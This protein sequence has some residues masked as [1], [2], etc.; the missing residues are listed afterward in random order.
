MHS[1]QYVLKRCQ[2]ELR[3]LLLSSLMG[4]QGRG[5][6]IRFVEEHVWCISAM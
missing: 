2:Q 3:N 1:F 6:Q 4:R 5:W